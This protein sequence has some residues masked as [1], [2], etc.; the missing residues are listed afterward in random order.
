VKKI[1]TFVLAILLFGS[2]KSKLA[3]KE[4]QLNYLD[5][6]FSASVSNN[7]HWASNV[8][9]EEMTLLELFEITDENVDSVNISF[10]DSA[11]IQLRYFVENQEIN[12]QYRGVFAK[13]GVFEV[14]FHYEK[15]ETIIRSYLNYSRVRLQLTNEN[16]FIVD[17]KWSH[18]GSFLL[19]FAGGGGGGGQAYF[20]CG[21]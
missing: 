13:Q 20:K 10:I 6:S 1:L 9:Y 18:S 3:L 16:D 7:S 11:Q 4:T 15:E 8:D 12:K 14:Y 19:I 2:C 17:R 5:Y 21:S